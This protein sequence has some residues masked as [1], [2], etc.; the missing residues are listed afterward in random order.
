MLQMR[1]SSFVAQ[2]LSSLPQDLQVQLLDIFVAGFVGKATKFYY[3][4]QC[5]GSGS[6]LI[7]VSWIRIRIDFGRLDPDP[8]L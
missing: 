6:A 5:C 7:L 3:L 4:K 1:P 2:K 8:H